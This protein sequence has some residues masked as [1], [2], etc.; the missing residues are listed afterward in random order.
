M[1]AHHLRGPATRGPQSRGP[2]SRGPPQKSPH[3]CVGDLLEVG[4]CADALIEWYSPLKGALPRKPTQGGPHLKGA[5]SRNPYLMGP[6]LRRPHFR[7]PQL[8]QAHTQCVEALLSGGSLVGVCLCA[9]PFIC[10]G[11]PF[12]G[13]PGQ[14]PLSPMPTSGPAQQRRTAWDV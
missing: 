4:I 1:R 14:L 12:C 3:S 11:P 6:H 8:K 10:G 9:G 13:G 2:H 7:R 5:N